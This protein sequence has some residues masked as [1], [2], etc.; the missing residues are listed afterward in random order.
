MTA[1]EL[2]RGTDEAGPLAPVMR[3]MSRIA[4]LAERRECEHLEA[5]RFLEQEVRRLRET[6]SHLRTST[7]PVPAHLR[8][9]VARAMCEVQAPPG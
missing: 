1:T 2:A 4:E 5:I 9:V 7:T 3:E 6:V 8:V